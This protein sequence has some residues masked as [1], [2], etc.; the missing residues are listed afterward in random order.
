MPP[1]TGA[2]YTTSSAG[3]H[4]HKITLSQA[5]L[6]TLGGGQQVTV[7]S[8]SD[9]GHTHSFAI[10]KGDNT[11]DGGGGSDPGGGW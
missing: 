4:T 1:A 5:Q 11:G 9:S 10:T 7:V 2:T 3:G 8:T 6:T